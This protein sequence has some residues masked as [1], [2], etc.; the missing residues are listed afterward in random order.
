MICQIRI[1][2]TI[3]VLMSAWL[4]AFAQAPDRDFRPRTASLS[5][6]VTVE[7]KPSANI[8]ITATE[9]PQ[10]IKEARIFSLGGLEFVDPYFYKTTT[11]SEGRYQI[12]G[13]PAGNY[14][15]SPQAPAHVP[16][17][18][19]LGLDASV[20]VTLDEGEAREKVDFALSRGGVITGRVTERLLRH[21]RWRV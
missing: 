11:D 16:E 18:N 12:T 6:R 9:D 1:I 20:R 14:R 2:V 15:I 17:S 13:L 10:G 7:G 3:T 8:T 5:G 21:P 4:Q 19:L